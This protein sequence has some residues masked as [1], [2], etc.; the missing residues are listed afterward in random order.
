MSCAAVSEP[1]SL[2]DKESYEPTAAKIL[3][4]IN[5]AAA[6][7]G[8]IGAQE[9]GHCL[10]AMAMG[11]DRFQVTVL[12]N[13]SALELGQ[14]TVEM[15]RNMSSLESTFF[16]ISGTMSGMASDV[17]TRELLK[18]GEVPKIMQPTLQWF[19]L[20]AK[21]GAYGELLYGIAK[22]QDYRDVDRWITF[23]LIGGYLTYNI[24]DLFISD[25]I[26][27]Y[28]KVLVGE[29]FYAKSNKAGIFELVA[30]PQ[31]GGAFLG[32]CCRY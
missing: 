10:A 11:A 28:F 1:K 15:H 4:P 21:S 18:S 27:R 6:Y 2:L 16:N 30:A 19:S 26:D 17:F 9:G 22:V 13:L 25:R 7:F 31:S 24:Y 5:I 29:D 20:F 12:P 8:S 3:L 23:S 14:T 32:F